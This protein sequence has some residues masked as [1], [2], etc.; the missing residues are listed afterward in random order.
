MAL[1]DFDGTITRKDSIIDFIFFSVGK[2]Q[3]ITGL[4]LLSPIIIGY[5]LKVI[6]NGRLK[7]TIFKFF[8]KGWPAIKFNQIALRYSENHL[9]RLIRRKALQRIKWHQA[10]GH[11]VAIVS[12]SLK[13]WLEHWCREHSLLLI[14]SEI[15]VK[16]DL[17]TGRISDCY[18]SEKVARITA[19]LDLGKYNFIYVYGDSNG[20]LEMLK[21]ANKQYYRNFR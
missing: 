7:E 9:P 17:L 18:G 3:A 15:E 5:E 16:D 2:F 14:S 8:F 21:L 20:D 11:T 12:A 19:E 1:F 13:N 4:V 6:N 10:Q